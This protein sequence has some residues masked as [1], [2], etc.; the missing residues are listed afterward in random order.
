MQKKNRWSLKA[1]FAG[2]VG[3]VFSKEIPLLEKLFIIGLGALY[4]L[5][6]LDIIPDIFFPVGFLDDFGIGTLILTYMSHRL[7][8][9]KEGQKLVESCSERKTYSGNKNIL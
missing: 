1:F 4:L 6:P 3:Y 2:V 7:T 5:L 9:I 8:K